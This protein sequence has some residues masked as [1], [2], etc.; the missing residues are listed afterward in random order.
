[1]INCG[2]FHSSTAPPRRE[3]NN[4]SYCTVTLSG[5]TTE[6]KSNFFPWT[7]S[8][9]SVAG[10]GPARFSILPRPS[11]RCCCGCCSQGP[12]RPRSTLRPSRS[13]QAGVRRQ[14]CVQCGPTPRVFSNPQPNLLQPAQRRHH[15]TTSLPAADHFPFSALPLSPGPWHAMRDCVRCDGARDNWVSRPRQ[16]TVCIVPLVMV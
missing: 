6:D 10:G 5:G 1:M 12:V 16:P 7:R 3:T 4:V 9:A 11:R 15:A 2:S 14:K 8:G 13:K